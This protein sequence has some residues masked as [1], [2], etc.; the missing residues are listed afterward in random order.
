MDINKLPQ[1]KYNLKDMS[2]YADLIISKSDE[3]FSKEELEFVLD[4]EK[5]TAEYFVK[6]YNYTEKEAQEYALNNR[7]TIRDTNKA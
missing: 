1:H 5:A 7:Q 6:A 2:R 4:M 3:E